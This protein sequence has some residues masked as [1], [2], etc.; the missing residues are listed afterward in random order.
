MLG[1]AGQANIGR[2]RGLGVMLAVKHVTVMQPGKGVEV[3][4]ILPAQG[5]KV[6]TR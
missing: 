3:I 6:V 2:V 4:A 5:L 1:V